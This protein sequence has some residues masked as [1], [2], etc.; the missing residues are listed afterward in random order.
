[1]SQA[2]QFWEKNLVEL[3][4]LVVSTSRGDF[5]HLV[6][7]VQE[8]ASDERFSVEFLVLASELADIS[9]LDDLPQVR[10]VTT[11]AKGLRLPKIDQD[12]SPYLVDLLKRLNKVIW[13]KEFDCAVLLGD[14]IELLLVAGSLLS[15]NIPLV[16]IHGGEETSGAIDNLVRNAV[17]KIASIHF[18]AY[19]EAASRLV[20]MLEEPERI[21]VSGSLAVDNFH[22]LELLSLPQ[23]EKR[24]GFEVEKNSVLVTFH[25]VTA[26]DANEKEVSLFFDDLER[27]D[28]QILVTPPNQDP[29][30]EL[31]TDRIDKLS[32]TRPTRVRKLPSLGT[33]LYYS[34]MQNVRIVVG[35]SSSG[36]FDAPISGVPAIDYGTRQGSRWRPTS[37]MH[38]PAK[39]GSL[40]SAIRNFDH[41]RPAMIA[42]CYGEPGVSRR[43]AQ[44][45]LNSKTLFAEP[46]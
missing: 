18:P 46:K 9:E 23:I 22:R 8:F 41:Q 25:P 15:R 26:G 44:A 45:L 34:L 28:A 19:P 37:V 42:H 10:Q 11:F 30:R 36:I 17:S 20:D 27:I 40:Q 6:P 33:Q 3:K 35:N 24:L 1:M 31:I 16:H 4:V 43:M 21:L 2:I 13:S 7:L 5:G 39:S 14:R 29:G 12:W 38:V 32:S